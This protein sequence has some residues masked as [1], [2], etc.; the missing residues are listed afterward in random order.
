MGA[1]LD[2]VL[3]DN[4]MYCGVVVCLCVVQTE[5]SCRSPS[6]SW[7]PPLW[8][9]SARRCAC[10]FLH[11]HASCPARYGELKLSGV[12][13]GAAQIIEPKG[14]GV[15]WDSIAGLEHAKATVKEVVVWPMVNPELFKGSRAP[16]QGLLLFGPPGTGKTLIGRAIAT[17]TGATFFS[18]SSSSLTSKWIGEGEKMVRALFAVARHLEVSLFGLSPLLRDFVVLCGRWSAT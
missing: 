17:S 11:P 3:S 12:E 16:P 10:A 15:E 4:D 2:K 5:G 9:A 6:P 18:I 14:S 13:V 1:H 7:T 8:S